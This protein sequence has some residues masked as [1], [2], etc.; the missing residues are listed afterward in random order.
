MKKFEDYVKEKIVKK[1]TPDINRAAYL[2]KE[3]LNRRKFILEL[4]NV[5]ELNDENANYF[6]E[7]AYDVIMELIRSKMFEKGF[8]ASGH[9]AHEAEISFLSELGFSE[10][11]LIFADD[12]RKARNGILYYGK[13]FEKEFALKVIGFMNDTVKKL[14]K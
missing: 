5:K 3:A 11:K 9:Y 12:L 1:I 4:L 14:A 2:K 8:R 6:I 13:K 10:D 7:L